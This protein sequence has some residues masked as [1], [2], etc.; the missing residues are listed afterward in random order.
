MKITVAKTPFQNRTLSDILSSSSFRGQIRDK[1][2]DSP[3]VLKV[4]NVIISCCLLERST[5]KYDNN[6]ARATGP[7]AR[8]GHCSMLL[9]CDLALS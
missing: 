5:K 4:L 3:V 1:R 2:T 6:R 9:L 7:N 8:C